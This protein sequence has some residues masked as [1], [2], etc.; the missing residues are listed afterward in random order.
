MKVHPKG[1]PASLIVWKG[2]P[3][4]VAYA[5]QSASVATS[6][7]PLSA[8]VPL[9]AEL[10]GKSEGVH[11]TGGTAASSMAVHALKSS[12]LHAS[13]AASCAPHS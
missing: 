5:W 1:L 9:M 3:S 2:S 6:A 11:V 10:V 4:D 7:L 12:V 13:A 8:Q